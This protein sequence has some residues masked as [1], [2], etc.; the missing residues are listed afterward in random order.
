MTPF[1]AESLP[2]AEC[3][4]L[5]REREKM[6]GHICANPFPSEPS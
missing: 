3:E 2:E 5:V 1:G 4:I 6:E